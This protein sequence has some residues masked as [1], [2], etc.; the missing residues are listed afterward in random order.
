MVTHF[1]NGFQERKKSGAV[2]LDLTCAYDTV[3]KRGL[4]LKLANILNCKMTLMLTMLADRKFRV[5]LNGNVSEYKYKY[6]QNGLPQGSVLSPILFNAY[7]ADI[8]NT[9]SRKYIFAV[10]VGLVAQAGT[11][12]EVEYIILNEDLAKVHNFFKSWHLIFSP[13]KSASIVFHLSNR[14]E[15][16]KLNLAVVIILY[17]PI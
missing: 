11:F 5:H 9:I 8:T 7:T 2:F 15:N 4:L 14:E 1:E 13:G 3:W 6:L 17:R 16:R 12:E 10:D